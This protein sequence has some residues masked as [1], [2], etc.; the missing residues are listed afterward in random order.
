MNSRRSKNKKW[1]SVP[2]ELCDQIE[3]VFKENFVELSKSGPFQVAGRIYQAELLLRVTH[4][5]NGQ[6]TQPKFEVSLDIE[7]HKE[8]ALKL[9]HLAVDCAASMVQEYFES[10]RDLSEFPRTW[11]STEIDGKKIFL[12]VS[13][14]NE[15]LDLEADRLLAQVDD[16]LLI[17]EKSDLENTDK[18]NLTG[19]EDPEGDLETAITMLGLK[20]EEDPADTNK[21]KLKNKTVKKRPSPKKIH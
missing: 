14:V 7:P 8:N 5:V 17:N 9:I 18:S 19:G 21:S 15:A 4:V 16:S 1:T 10:D 20:D 2:K 13:T 3:E 11:E 12:Q 6:L